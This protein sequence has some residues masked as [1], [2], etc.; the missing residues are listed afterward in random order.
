MAKCGVCRRYYTPGRSR[1]LCDRD[2]WRVRRLKEKTQADLERLQRETEIARACIEAALHAFDDTDD[3]VAPMQQ[4]N[5][6]S[7]S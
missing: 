7:G 3:A 2:Y 1:T 5:R 4:R 6:Y